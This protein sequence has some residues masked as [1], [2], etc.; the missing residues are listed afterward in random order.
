M[1]VRKKRIEELTT[2]LRSKDWDLRYESARILGDIDK[3]DLGKDLVTIIQREED[4]QIRKKACDSLG[5]FHLEIAI[6]A[7]IDAMQ[8][9]RSI[10]VRY[11][12]ARALGEMKVKQALEPL[13]E[14]LAKEKNL[15]SIFWFNIALAKIE[16]D[17]D[18]EGIK[19]L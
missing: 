17:L 15:S 1:N 16:D 8:N 5:K 11:T 9:D 18:G 12:A 7:L 3:K 14:Q 2:K 10:V 4:Q 6:P 13:K 19:A